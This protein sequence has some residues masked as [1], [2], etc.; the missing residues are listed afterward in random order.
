MNDIAFAFLI[1]EPIG[2]AYQSAQTYCAS[3]PKHALVRLR[4]MARLCCDELARR[5][6]ADW[7]TGSL[8]DRIEALAEHR[9]VDRVAK[10]LLHELRRKGNMGAHPEDFPASE[11]QFTAAAVAAMTSARALLLW[12]YRAVHPGLAPPPFELAAVDD[13]HMR[14]VCYRAVMEGDPE[15]EHIIGRMMQDKAIRAWQQSKEAAIANDGGMVGGAEFEKYQ[16]QALYWLKNAAD[17]AYPQALYDYGKALA[18]EAAGPE[19]VALG[20][21]TVYRAAKLGNPDAEAFVGA[22]FLFGSKTFEV[23]YA[24]ARMYLERAAETDHPGALA[25]LGIMHRKGLGLPQDVAKAAALTLRA[26]RSGFP[27][28]QFNA[29]VAFSAGEGVE[30]DQKAAVAWLRKASAQGH[31]K[32]R[33]ALAAFMRAG[34]AQHAGFEEIESLIRS[35]LVDD[36][37]ARFE[38]AELYAAEGKALHHV[39]EAASLLQQCYEIALNEGDLQLAEKCRQASPAAVQALLDAIPQMDDATLRSALILKTFF[40]HDHYPH[41]SRSEQLRKFAALAKDVI[42]GQRSAPAS[43]KQGRNAPCACGSGRKHKA[44]CGA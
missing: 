29:A 27:Q 22:R 18:A 10:A 20:E 37:M 43:A 13:G 4:S 16:K 12:M 35:A 3:L 23:D 7:V 34:L 9:I 8:E 15:A 26:A 14:D 32:A 25:N 6:G 28:A 17:A 30:Q 31:A 2:A 24:Q 21:Q 40:D 39:L 1:S 38:L 42:E 5:A 19:N 11:D 44:C 41:R 36:N 33:L